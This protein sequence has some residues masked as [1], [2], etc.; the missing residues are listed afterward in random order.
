M[1][2]QERYTQYCKEARATIWNLMSESRATDINFKFPNSDRE[3]AFN[4]MLKRAIVW[5]QKNLAS[6]EI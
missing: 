1:N 5:E 6:Q 4:D 2:R 3:R